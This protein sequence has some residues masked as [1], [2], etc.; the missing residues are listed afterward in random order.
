MIEKQPSCDDDVEPE[1]MPVDEAQRRLFESLKPLQ[2]I[3]E[4]A[5]EQAL[6]RV[7]SGDVVSPFNVPMQANSAMDGY[8]LSAASIPDDAEA[9]LVLAGLAWAGKPFSGVVKTGECVR[10]YTGA[11]MPEGADTVVIQEHVR[12]LENRIDI[13]NDVVSFKNV[14]QAGE[15]VKAGQQIFAK[16]RSLQAADIGV[17]ASLG[18]KSV[19]VYKKLVV[20]FFTTGDELQA[21]D[22][23]TEG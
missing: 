20:A 18:I 13:D 19:Q 22:S 1:L 6:H 4:V 9:T 7:L 10:I 23:H 12:A 5:L 11:I 21:L 8:A 14:R 15:D 17:L 16:G 3:E 2:N